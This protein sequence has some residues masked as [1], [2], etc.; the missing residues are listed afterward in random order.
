LAVFA[1]ALNFC[2]NANKRFVDGNL[3][4]YRQRIRMPK[5][6]RMFMSLAAL[7]TPPGNP[8]QRSDNNGLASVAL[9]CGVGLL[10]SLIAM[11]MGMPGAWY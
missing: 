8:P 6:A 1:A 4:F 10:L 11:I 7:T 9:F 3:R 5:A 2:R